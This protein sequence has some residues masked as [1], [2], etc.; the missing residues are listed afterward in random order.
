MFDFEQLRS[1]HNK[2]TRG[3]TAI[4]E[5]RA[6]NSA[7]ALLPVQF[8]GQP[9]FP[10]H[11]GRWASRLPQL[12]LEVPSVEFIQVQSVT[13]TAAVVGEGRSPNPR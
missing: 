3:E 11:E 8:Y 10:L 9:L 1:A 2:L 5:S 4:L 6:F 7:S 13:G 12:A